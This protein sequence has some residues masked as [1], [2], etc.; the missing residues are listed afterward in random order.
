MAVVRSEVR[1]GTYYDSVV[2][3]QLQRALAAQTGVIDAGVVM[4]TP[5]NRELLGQSGLLP[6]SVGAAG[7][8]DMLIVV[9]AADEQAAVQALG[10]VDGLLV[11]R[12]ATSEQDTFRPRSLE[13]ALKAL[14]QARWVQISVPGRY[15]AGVARDALN[16]GRHVFL[17]SDNVAVE[18]EIELKEMARQKGLL[19]MGPDCGTAIIPAWAWALLTGCGAARLGWWGRQER[20]CK[21]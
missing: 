16:L 5:A 14:P 10:Q 9:K 12:R 2:L 8:D 15:A 6:E 1:S 21:R 7:P 17:Y 13:A 20:G 18:A 4:A 19:L 11:R 3:M